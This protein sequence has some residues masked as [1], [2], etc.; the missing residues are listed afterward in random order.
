[1]SWGP[2]LADSVEGAEQMVSAYALSAALSLLSSSLGAALTWPLLGHTPQAGDALAA[3][4][5]GLTASALLFALCAL[6]LLGVR[7]RKAAASGRPSLKV[8]LTA[9]KL[10]GLAALMGFGAGLG[11][12]NAG[13]W[14][15]RKHGA[16]APQLGA[17]SIASNVLMA[18]SATAAPAVSA[19]LGSALAVAALRAASAPLL[20]ATALSSSLAWASALYVLRSAL[21][22]A[23]DPLVSS[24]HMRL[25]K[26]EERA[27][28]A[29]LST[30]AWQAAGSAGSFLGG[31]LMDLN[32]DLPPYATA[33]VYLA[34]S[35]LFHAALRGA[36]GR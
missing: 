22:N 21:V 9:L 17:L 27:R 23:A 19:K 13:Y 15:A 10:A 29:M 3:Y 26:P 31:L 5:L 20:A 34:H 35:A 24:L 33:A 7:E 28:M 30:L 16:E 18:A 8:S 2:L 1:M 4:K 12:W 6:P 32:V 14:F 25:V 36:E 11:V